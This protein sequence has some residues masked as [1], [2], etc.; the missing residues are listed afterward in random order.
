MQLLKAHVTRDIFEQKIAIQIL[1]EF[2][3]FEIRY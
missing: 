3:V 2:G 1:K